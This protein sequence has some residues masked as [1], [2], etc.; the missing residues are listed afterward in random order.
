MTFGGH[1]LFVARVASFAPKLS[2]GTRDTNKLYA[3][4]ESRDYHYYQHRR[5]NRTNVF[6]KERLFNMK[7]CCRLQIPCTA[8]TL[9]VNWLRVVVTIACK[10]SFDMRLV[11]TI[12]D[13]D[14]N[15]LLD[16]HF[17]C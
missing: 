8:H 5:P 3:L 6:C 15:L 2:E 11:I 4:Q 7:L 10:M 14:T 13:L 17:L 16:V 12:D 1:S 9:F